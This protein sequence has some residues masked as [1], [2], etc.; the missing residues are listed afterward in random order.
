MAAKR[1]NFGSLRKLPSGRW[2]ARYTAPGGK[3]T[4]APMTFDT[5]GDALAW[6][7]TVRADLV[8]GAWL[9][10]DVDTTFGTYAATWL[11]HRNPQT[12]H[13]SALPRPT[14]PAPSANLPRRTRVPPHARAG[15]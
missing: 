4:T 8:R 5:K 13:T 10:P 1:S 15:P 11:E 12:P 3:T 14:R 7:S 9:P 2:Q 6:L